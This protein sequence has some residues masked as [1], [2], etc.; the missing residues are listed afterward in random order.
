[1]SVASPGLRHQVRPGLQAWLENRLSTANATAKP[2]A[3]GRTINR[4]SAI[5]AK[6]GPT[7]SNIFCSPR[8]CAHDSL[9]R[10]ALRKTCDDG[11]PRLPLPNRRRTGWGG[12]FSFFEKQPHA[13]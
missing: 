8:R 6:N 4:V 11:S 7:R 12:G 2:I 1:M 3:L 9:T 5:L 13:K 10:G